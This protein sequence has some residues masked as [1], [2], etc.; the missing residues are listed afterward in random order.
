M[1][2]MEILSS[3]A[4]K[5]LSETDSDWVSSV[6]GKGRDLAKK[7]DEV[8]E[9]SAN[10]VLDIIEQRKEAIH[11]LGVGGLISVIT[12][13][14]FGEEDQARL[15]FLRNEAS[16]EERRAAQQAAQDATVSE[17]V[18]REAAWKEIKEMGEELGEMAIKAIPILLAAA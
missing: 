10:T 1:S 14:Y 5:T 7:L 9:F 13:F 11:S 2:L 17:K 16:F 15:V 8:E 3:K 18:K 6:I 4:M 12:N